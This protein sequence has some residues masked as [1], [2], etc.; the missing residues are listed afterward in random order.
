MINTPDMPTPTDRD[1]APWLP[2]HD[3]LTDYT[4]R[5]WFG[6]EEAHTM[7][8]DRIVSVMVITAD[9]RGPFDPP[10][11]GFEL[12]SGTWV[13][14]RLPDLINATFLQT[15][16]AIVNDHVLLDRTIPAIV[17]AA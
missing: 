11:V 13:N 12:E 16:R 3:D 1:I 7:I 15:A 9:A 10:E 14:V 17:V 5:A 6:D 8:N 4:L 2:L